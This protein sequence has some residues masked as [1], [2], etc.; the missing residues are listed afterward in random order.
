MI[1]GST[2]STQ[3]RAKCVDVSRLQTQIRCLSNTLNL[4]QFYKF[5]SSTCLPQLPQFCLFMSVMSH[6]LT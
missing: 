3:P 2:P 1:T 6:N 4:P 5:L